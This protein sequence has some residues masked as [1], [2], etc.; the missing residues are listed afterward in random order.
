[1]RAE[2]CTPGILKRDPTSASPSPPRGRHAKRRTKEEA[3]TKSTTGEGR[4]WAKEE[5]ENLIENL[6]T[7]TYSTSRNGREIMKNF[8]KILN[9]PRMMQL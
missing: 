1:M 9:G 7:L 3:P 2:A 6:K 4:G 8:A 5:A